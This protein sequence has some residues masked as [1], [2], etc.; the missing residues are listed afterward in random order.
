MQIAAKIVKMWAFECS[1][2]AWF[3]SEKPSC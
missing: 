3:V 1:G 2:L